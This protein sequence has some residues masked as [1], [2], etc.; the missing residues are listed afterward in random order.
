MR[1]RF[2]VYLAVI[3]LG[4]LLIPNNVTANMNGTFNETDINQISADVNLPWGNS[5]M[6]L[7]D[8]TG[9]IS[10]YWGY[11][12]THSKIY[13]MDL[14]L[15]YLEGIIILLVGIFIALVILV[16]KAYYHVTGD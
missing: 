16:W 2:F 4:V 7:T 14:I 15:E 9:N 3:I 5:S 11:F 8:H 6:N 10:V 13:G 1:K 12:D